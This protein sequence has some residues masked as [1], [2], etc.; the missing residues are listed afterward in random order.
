MVEGHLADP[1][2]TDC[3]MLLYCFIPIGQI[4]LIEFISF[5]LEELTLVDHKAVKKD[6]EKDYDALIKPLVEDDVPCYI[7]YR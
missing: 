6:W 3:V 1:L 5:I 4:S 7:L 2:P